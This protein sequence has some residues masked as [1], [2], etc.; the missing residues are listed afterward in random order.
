MN[1]ARNNQNKT[2]P[3]RRARYH[4]PSAVT[5]K[6]QTVPC[7][8]CKIELWTLYPCRRA[9]Y[10]QPSAVTDC[11]A[12]ILQNWALNFLSC[13]S[14]FNDSDKLNMWQSNIASIKDKSVLVLTLAR[15]GE[16][17][18]CYH[19]VSYHQF[20]THSYL[21]CSNTCYN[22]LHSERFLCYILIKVSKL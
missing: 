16:V 1:F 12:Q 3:C 2:Y 19:N 15:R 13:Q 6:L 17:E 22:L 18:G 7:K 8:Y 21:D 14:K 4:Q 11:S 5:D 20:V 10:H 9:R